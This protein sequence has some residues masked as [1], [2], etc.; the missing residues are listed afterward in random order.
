MEENKNKVNNKFCNVKSFEYKEDKKE[1]I[2]NYKI[3]GQKKYQN[4]SKDGYLRLLE[5]N[6]KNKTIGM[7]IRKELKK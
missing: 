3:S 7:K 2:V 1:L 6:E 4:F 5:S